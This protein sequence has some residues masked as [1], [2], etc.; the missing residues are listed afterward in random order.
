MSAAPTQTDSSTT[1]DGALSLGLSTPPQQLLRRTGLFETH[2]DLRAKMVD[3]GGWE[4]PVEYAG[5]VAEHNAVRTREK[6][7]RWVRQTIGSI[8]F[9]NFRD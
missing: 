2:K 4:M 6:D 8:I 1:P 7:I 9:F 3:F 5:L